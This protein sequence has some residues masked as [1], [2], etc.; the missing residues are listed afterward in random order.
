MGTDLPI[1]MTAWPRMMTL[2]VRSLCSLAIGRSQAFDAMA[3]RRR[4]ESGDEVVRPLQGYSMRIPEMARL[5]TSCWICSVP[6]K[7]SMILASRWN[8]ST[9]YSRT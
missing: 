8:R 3:T 9:G 2:A 1:C 5:M 4:F 7:M 6:S